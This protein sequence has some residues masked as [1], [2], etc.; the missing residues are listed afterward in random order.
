MQK[1]GGRW[2][3]IKLELLQKYLV[4][5]NNVLKNKNFQRWY[6]DAF[7][8]SGH[9]LGGPEQELQKGSPLIA[10]ECEPGFH[11]L[12]FIEARASN[13]RRLKAL[14]DAKDQ[15]S[16]RAVVRHGD[17]NEYLLKF[18][19]AMK[20]SWRAVVF[21][22]PFAMQVPWST[23]EA[24]AATGKCD[25]WILFPT[26]SV[27]RLLTRSG[28]RDPK[29]NAKLNEVLG[30]EDWRSEFYRPT[31]MTDMFSEQ[32]TQLKDADCS[33]IV[34]YYHS[35]LAAIF[36]GGVADSWRML[37]NSNGSP[38]FAFMFALGN[39]SP[40]ARARA[41]SIANHLLNRA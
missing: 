29:W 27:N 17:A 14:V 31:G 25:V 40:A 35:R 12:L 28:H 8:G 5:Y 3:T 32:P 13:Y 4:A 20:R 39:P 22:D 38:L 33:T 41:L 11:K 23:L 18:C 37:C 21:L 30:T 16:R 26:S 2:T 7:A 36:K 1:F 10:L 6:V 15:W 24:L 34:S 9:S 19:R